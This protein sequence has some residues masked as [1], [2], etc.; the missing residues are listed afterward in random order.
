GLNCL[1]PFRIGI[2][3]PPSH[4]HT[5]RITMSIICDNK[6]ES[7]YERQRSSIIRALI[8]E[9]NG[10]RALDIGCG[11]GF[12][13]RILAEKGWNVTAVDIEKENIILASRFASKTIVDN[14]ISAVE[15]L[16][17]SRFDFFLMLELIEHLS[18]AEGS[19]LLKGIKKLATG[20]SGLLLSS[21]NRLS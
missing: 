13:T 11:S 2:P 4:P 7:T 18:E 19:H 21:P 6:Y 14:A 5:E 20:G 1:H 15:K 10:R 16:Q 8:P 9:G 12:Y 3:Q 17:G